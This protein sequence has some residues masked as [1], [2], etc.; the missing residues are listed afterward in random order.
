M[1]SGTEACM[2]AIRLARAYTG[3]SK[4]IKF[5][6]CYHGHVDG[7]LVRAGS[8]ALTSGIP[9]SAGVPDS[10]ASETLIAD[11]NDLNSV[12]RLFSEHEGQIAGIIVEPIAG[13]MGVVPPDPG[14]LT[15]L[16][17][18]CLLYTSPSPRD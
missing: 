7:L 10:Y 8:G 1:S 4:I 16:R 3:K 11:F 5:A 13:N 2:S 17:N 12:E 6:G 14:F 9:D 15:G 18:I